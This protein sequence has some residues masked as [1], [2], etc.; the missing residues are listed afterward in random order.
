[1]EVFICGTRSDV[2]LYTGLTKFNFVIRFSN[3]ARHD[4]GV[5][6]V[7][8][9]L[10]RSGS[11]TYRRFVVVGNTYGSFFLWVLLLVPTGTLGPFSEVAVC[12]V[13]YIY[14]VPTLSSYGPVGEFC[15]VCGVN[16]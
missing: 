3:V 10:G 12:G 16:V 13:F 15:Y 14:M 6:R 5:V 8:A 1:M 11:V 9:L 2:N 7:N 4:L